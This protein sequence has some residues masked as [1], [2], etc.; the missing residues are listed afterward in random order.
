MPNHKSCEKRVR[1]SNLERIRNR[2]Y[3]SNLRNTIKD[4]REE[5]NKEEALKK[6]HAA[7]ILLDKAVTR[8]IVHKRTASRN[9]SRLTIH[10]Q[11]LG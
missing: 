6:L 2:A 7:T 1:T 10:V 9:K 3:R 11:K 8:G 4:V 5:T